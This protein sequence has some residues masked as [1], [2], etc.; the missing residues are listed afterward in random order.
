MILFIKKIKTK[1]GIN[2]F[3]DEKIKK[4]IPK[5]YIPSVEDPTITLTCNH[6]VIAFKCE[7]AIKP[8]PKPKLKKKGKS[9]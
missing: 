7:K 5:G 6:M 1:E 8:T 3:D 4:S 2:T 9:S